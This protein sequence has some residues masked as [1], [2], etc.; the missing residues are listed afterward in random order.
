MVRMQKISPLPM[1]CLFTMIVVFLF[2]AS[3][4]SAAEE[5]PRGE[6]VLLDVYHDIGAKL[7]KNSFGFPLYIESFDQAGRLQA[8]AYGIIAHP[9]GSVLNALRVPANWCNIASLLPDVKAC[10]YEEQPRTWQMTFYSGDTSRQSSGYAD[11]FTYQCR[12]VEQRDG[13]LGIVLSAAEGPFG[14]TNHRMMFE[15]MP[16]NGE[17]TF[18]HVRYAYNYGFLV[19]VAKTLFSA[20]PGR[21][22]TGF[23]V[24]GIDGKGNP[25]YVD[26]PRGAIERNA[27]KC[28]MAIQSFVDT[29]SFPEVSRFEM[30]ISTWYD[31]ASRFRKQLL[32]MDKK[33][34]IASKTEEHRKQ[35]MLQQR[36]AMN[37][38]QSARHLNPAD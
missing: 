31:L 38:R 34:Y 28:Y 30:M 19:R 14:T 32:E 36:I 8:D 22:K 12:T 6:D 16:L 35:V 4:V 25:V 21:G 37:L 9:F 1:F 24:K 5:K 23:T 7:E 11:Q 3:A 2:S 13:Y 17:R 18:V 20:I 33:D 29:L 15:A 10:T 26:G 27:V